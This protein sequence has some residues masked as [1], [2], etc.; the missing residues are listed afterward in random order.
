MAKV[1]KTLIALRLTAESVSAIKFWANEDKDSQANVVD[2]AV[3]MYDE[4]RT[5][6]GQPTSRKGRYPDGVTIDPPFPM[7]SERGADTSVPRGF[8]IQCRHCGEHGRGATKFATICFGCK[9]DGHS[10]DPRD[11]P[12]CTGGSAI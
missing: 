9:S 7:P 5:H 4:T 3:K 1:A 12:V 6:G 2:A 10:N 11:C 8:P